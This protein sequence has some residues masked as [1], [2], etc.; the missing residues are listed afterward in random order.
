MAS[1]RK[2]SSSLKVGILTVTALII[3][4]FTVL[5]IK[6]RSLS[7]GERIEVI[8]HD[9][10]GIRAGSGV[11]MMGL[12]IGQ[13][14]EIIPV[15]D[16]KDSHVKV[17]FVITEKGVKIPHASTISIQ[18]SG[19]IGEQ[20]LEVMPPKVNYIYME[21]NKTSTNIK[22]GQDVY[23]VLSNEYTKIGKVEDARVI[24]TSAAPLE[25]KTKFKTKNTLK[26]GYTIDL[27]GLILDNSNITAYLTNNNNLRFE[28][29]NGAKMEAPTTNS[30]YTIIEP[31]R[32]SDFLELQYR[33]AHSLASVN[34]RVMEILSDEFVSD[35]RESVVN[36]NDL[37]K[38]ANTTID[39]AM[40]LI[41]SSKEE[42]DAVLKQTNILT[43][44]LSV[45]SDNLNDIV[46]DKQTQQDLRNTIKS[47]GRLSD[48]MN[49]IIE[50]PETKEML[51]DLGEI[52]RNLADI[53]CYINEFAGDEK[54]RKDL[55]E[56]VSGI[57]NAVKEVNENL[58]KV[59][60]VSG[61]EQLTINNS[62]QDAM[63]TTR[64]LRKFSE[65]LNKRFLLF[66]LMF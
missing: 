51:S 17:K 21:T 31:M 13:I 25:Y 46:G 52:S 34:D 45:L 12:R 4:I 58:K 3:L 32:I 61:E 47:V 24:P 66:R 64:N 55:K 44:K 23:M 16:G 1:N 20:F 14:E 15:V 7:S 57:N 65:K 11:Q 49:K 54:L 40:A 59:N 41:D 5:W 48:N 9:I 56:S 29:K 26:I 36:V 18:Q 37:T 2:V 53:S 43:K 60:E 35:I 27:P 33:A 30:P 8:F 22:E 28:L 6:G 39:K 19:L 42:L 50:T 62:I 63:I 10:N 38:K